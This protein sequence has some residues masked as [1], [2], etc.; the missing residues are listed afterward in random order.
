MP[1]S[2]DQRT[3][4]SLLD[5]FGSCITDVFYNHLY[6]R[7]IAVHE[8]TSTGI[9]ECYRN[10][11]KEY[12]QES[13]SPKF[14]TILLNSIHYYLR[15]STIYNDISYPDFITLYTSLFVPHMYV[16]S[17]SAEQ[18]INIVSMIIGSCVNEFASEINQEHIRCIIDDH[19]DPVNVEVLQ[20]AIL[21]IIIKQRDLNYNRF[22]ESQKTIKNKNETRKTEPSNQKQKNNAHALAMAK[23]S[24]AFKKSVLDKST[25]KKKNNAL[26]KQNKI[27]VNKFNEIKTLLLNQLAY[28]KEQSNYISLLQSQLK[29]NNTVST[30]DQTNSNESQQ[31]QSNMVSE[32]NSSSPSYDTIYDSADGDD[33]FSVQYV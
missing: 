30:N 22:I 15:M 6:D 11:I 25:L 33:L 19:N 23:L 26:T 20:D 24:S 8:K 4:L 16:A 9:T 12:V 10:V 1:T 7:A 29:S 32:M 14:Y 18:K 31:N 17:L 28:Q 3:I 21:K 13:S 5:V 2:F 27:L